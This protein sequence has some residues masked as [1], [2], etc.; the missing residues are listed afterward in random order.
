MKQVKDTENRNMEIKAIPFTLEESKQI[1]INGQKIGVIRGHAAAFSLDRMDDQIIKGAFQDTLND[2]RRRDNRPI[3]MRFQHSMDDLIGGF[4]I[5]LAFEDDK[6]LFVEGHIN[7]QVQRGQEAFSLAKQGIMTDMSIGF[8]IDEF[9]IRQLENGESLRIIKKLSLR[10]ISLVDEPANIDATIT[11]VKFDLDKQNWLSLNLGD[12]A[13]VRNAESFLRQKGLSNKKR[14]QLIS[15]LKEGGLHNIS[16]TAEP[17]QRDADAGQKAPS[18]LEVIRKK[19]VEQLVLHEL[20]K[21]AGAKNVR[22]KNTRTVNR[23]ST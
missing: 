7:L 13:G 23:T 17:G 20:Q 19:L 10:E 14:S 18:D 3:R 8:F 6:G 16:V 1:E 12:I 22:N 11:D 5:E 15:L 9:E 2:H 4:P 21:I